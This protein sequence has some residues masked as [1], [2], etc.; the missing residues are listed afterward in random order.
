M[1]V[2]HTFLYTSLPSLHNYNVKMPSNFMLYNGGWKQAMTKFSFAQVGSLRNN[3]K[4]HLHW[5][6]LVNGNKHDIMFIKP[7]IRFKSNI[8]A[9]VTIISAKAP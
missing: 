5:T 9:A 1:H 4:I 3:F 6:F 7:P 2:Q 8:F